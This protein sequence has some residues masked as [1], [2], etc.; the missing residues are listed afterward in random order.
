MTTPPTGAD[1]I[2]AALDEN[3]RDLLAYLERRHPGGE[4]ADLLA[5]TMTTAWRRVEDLPH[6]PV[7]ARMWLFGI[8]R[9]VL[10]NGQRSERR[11]WRLADRLRLVLRPKTE[12]AADEGLA[13][14]DAVDRL[15]TDLA[16]LV[17]LVH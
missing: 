16:E 17:R 9:N 8:A 4:A 7:Q 1:R 6:E 12:Q 11:R 15:P 10:A 2:T 5:E 14:R 3:A 13:V